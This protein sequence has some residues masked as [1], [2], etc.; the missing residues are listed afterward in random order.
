MRT[1]LAALAFFAA[2][3]I[4]Q[5][6]EDFIRQSVEGLKAQTAAH[7]GTWR[8]GQESKWNV[9]QDKAEIVFT[10]PDGVVARAPVQII[11][12]LNTESNSFLWGWDHPSIVPALRKHAAAAREW[13][14]KN[15]V[16][17]FTTRLVPTSEEEAWQFTAVAARIAHANGA[18]RAR[19]GAVLVFVTF[20][21]IQLSRP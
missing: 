4:A 7:S 17:K 15:N 3:A 18:Y 5:T 2:S 9:D 10:F 12:T 8:L 16:Q 1:V 20:G 11:G 19:A 14:E 21:E 6:P 13:G